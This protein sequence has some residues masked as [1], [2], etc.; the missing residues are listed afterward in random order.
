MPR[1]KTLTSA[2]SAA[3]CASIAHDRHPHGEGEE[4]EPRGS[5]AVTAPEQQVPAREIHGHDDDGQEEREGQLDSSH[6][7]GAELEGLHAGGAAPGGDDLEPG[8]DPT[9]ARRFDP[10]GDVVAGRVGPLPRGAPVGVV[11]GQPLRRDGAETRAV[12]ARLRE[13][14]RPVGLRG[15]RARLLDLRRDGREQDQ[16]PPGVHLHAGHAADR[17]RRLQVRNAARRARGDQQPRARPVP[18]DDQRGLRGG[19]AGPALRRLVVLLHPLQV[20]HVEAPPD[21]LVGGRRGI[22]D[23][24]HQL[25]GP[26]LEG[27]RGPLQRRRRGDLHAGGEHRRDDQRRRHDGQ[28]GR[29]PCRS[30]ALARRERGH[31]LRR[32]RLAG[33]ERL[34]QGIA[35]REGRRHR[36]RGLR[37]VRGVLL[38]A[39]QDGALGRG[40]EVAHDGRRL[41]GQLLALARQLRE[42]AAVKGP[43]PGEEL[44]ED[45]AE[46]VHV[47]A[48]GHLAP[49]QLL[50][51]HVG[52][53]AGADVVGADARPPGRRGRSR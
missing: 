44:V 4:R 51:G 30:Q 9:V 34:G 16:P 2:M 17:L 10:D 33:G 24:P 6:L 19:D 35:A 5:A 42:G 43:L 22:S 29:R 20:V 50:G 48:H 40:I 11:R 45:E 21:R 49:G 13:Q 32:R 36:H 27:G 18:E 47:A 39:A 25:A 8:G 7:A 46:R 53:R 37:P 3:W 31:H 12:Q 38:E 1:A 23:A 28:A 14:R 26:V 15:R 52:G 41:L